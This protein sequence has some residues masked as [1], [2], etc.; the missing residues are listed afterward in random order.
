M[1][2]K[3]FSNAELAENLREIARGQRHGADSRRDELRATMRAELIKAAP[4]VDDDELEAALDTM[5]EGVLAVCEL[6]DEAAERL[7]PSVQVD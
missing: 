3:S 7:S 2:V 6:M 4:S 1:N 5:L